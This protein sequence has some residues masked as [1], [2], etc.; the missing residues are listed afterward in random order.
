MEKVNMISIMVK[1]DNNNNID[2]ASYSVKKNTLH[3][4]EESLTDENN[5]EKLEKHHSR[6]QITDTEINHG[7]NQNEF[8]ESR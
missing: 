8:K 5:V 4:D 3:V 1:T 6:S 7:D 2:I